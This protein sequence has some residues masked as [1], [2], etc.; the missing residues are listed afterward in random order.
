M[1]EGTVE[2]DI[3][4]ST[5]YYILPVKSASDAPKEPEESESA[6]PSALTSVAGYTG[7]GTQ[8]REAVER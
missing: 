4:S 8:V 6:V 1:E 2:P 3:P 5:D 7:E